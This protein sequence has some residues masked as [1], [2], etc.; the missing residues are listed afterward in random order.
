MKPIVKALPYLALAAA[1][2]T[3]ACAQQSASEQTGP[4]SLEARADKPTPEMLPTVKPGAAV[5]IA[6]TQ[7][8][9]VGPGDRGTIDLTITESYS[10][11]LLTLEI[12]GDDGISVSGAS[13]SQTF[14]MADQ[15]SH[16]WSVN[17]GAEVEGI[18]YLRIR[19]TATPEDGPESG[20]SF[21]IRVDV[22]D[23]T[24]AASRKTTEATITPSGE[25]VIIMEAQE[26]IE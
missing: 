5:E 22:G 26:T 19:A 25:A 10:S 14:Q 15:S 2:L 24:K 16:K 11:G 1:L 3:T 13:V 9:A 7:R 4:A 6:H 21:A 18:Q 17:F 20:R 12:R 8:A 23:I